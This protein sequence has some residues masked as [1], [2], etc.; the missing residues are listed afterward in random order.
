MKSTIYGNQL[1]LSYQSNENGAAKITIRG[2]SGGLYIEDTFAVTVNPVDDPPFVANAIFDVALDINTETHEIE[3]TNVF[4]DI[5]NSN[6]SKSILN[7]T[8]SDFATVAITDNNLVISHQAGVEG[9]TQITVQG[10]SNGVSVE[11][12]FN[13]YAYESDLAPQIAASIEDITVV[14]NAASTDIDLAS[15]FTDPD[16]DDLSIAKMV[17][18]NT[19]DTL[20]F[21]SISGNIL[22]LDYQAGASGTAMITVRGTSRGKFVDDTFTVTVL[23]VDD[24]PVIV[25]IIQDIAVDEDASDTLIDLTSVFTDPDNDDQDIIKTIVSNTNESLVSGII[26]GNQ[27]VLN[28]VANASGTATLIVRATSGGKS[29]ETSFDVVVAPV[30]D[31]P[32]IATTIN[33]IMVNEDAAEQIVDLTG[34]FTDIDNYDTNIQLSITNNSNNNLVAASLSGYSMTLSYLP[35]QSGTATITIRGATNGLFVEDQ[36]NI[37]VNA[38]DDPPVVASAIADISMG[39]NDESY[40]IDLTNVFMDIDNNLIVKTIQSNTNSDL[41]TASIAENSLVISHQAGIEGETEITLQAISN[42]QMVSDSFKIFV[43]ASDVAPEISSAINDIIVLEDS[44][45]T[46]IDLTTVFTDPDS[47]DQN[48]DKLLVSNTNDTFVKATIDNNTLTLSYVPDAFGTST[49]TVRGTSQGKSIDDSFTVTITPVDDPPMI[50]SPL[51]DIVVDENAFNT[52]IGLLSVFK[53]ADN[54]NSAINIS[55]LQ[56]TNDSLLTA[57]LNE[58]T[59]LLSYNENQ[60]GEAIISIRGESNGLFI[61]DTFTVTVNPVDSA[62]EIN[63]PVADIAVEMNAANMTIPLNN[64]FIDPDNDSIST[65]ILSNT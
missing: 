24:P 1:V 32:M 23:S 36:L 25:N 48:I 11:D 28:Y 20:V 37:T 62:P 58:N 43:D 5:D 63:I 3:L 8:N 38:V 17:F 42:G 34:L 52:S 19:N 50:Q 27:L 21:A 13:V 7:N 55:V 45:N 59:L 14:E 33:A 41:A 15:V 60:Y 64:V 35:D 9:E 56:N 18:S 2:T 40:L 51:N 39:V 46:I 65:A 22:T 44:D 49:I 4:V 54:D 16:N 57:S 47:N 53:D 31:P 6:I 12:T 26:T 10:L 61:D 30:D 29:V